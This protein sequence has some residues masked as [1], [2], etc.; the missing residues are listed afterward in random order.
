MEGAFWFLIALLVV[1]PLGL[2]YMVFG[3]LKGTRSGNILKYI[4]FA[5]LGMAVLAT[6]LKV[7]RG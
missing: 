3:P 4:A 2:L 6:V 7:L 5:Q 1:V